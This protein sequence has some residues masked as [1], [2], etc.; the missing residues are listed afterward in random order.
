MLSWK[1]LRPITLVRAPMFF[2]DI[3]NPCMKS[4]H[5]WKVLTHADKS[6]EQYQQYFSHITVVTSD[7]AYFTILITVVYRKKILLLCI[8]AVFQPYNGTAYNIRL[9]TV[10]NSIQVVYVVD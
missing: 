5:C 3:S 8:Y 6:F 10:V 9:I 4:H 2:V 1:F 7:T